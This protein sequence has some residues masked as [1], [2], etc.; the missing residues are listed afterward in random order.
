[1]QYFNEKELGKPN[2]NV[3]EISQSVWGGIVGLINKHKSD[4]YFGYGF[5]AECLDGKGVIDCSAPNFN[6]ALNAEIPKLAGSIDPS[7]PPDTLTI[8][9]SIQFCHKSIGK[10]INGSWHDYFG[11]YDYNDFDV[12]EGRRIFRGEIETLFSRNGIAFRLNEL[13]VNF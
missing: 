7:H 9:D 3:E 11:H 5:P 12:E 1:M 8:L 13:G 2:R 6:L 10:P 4:G